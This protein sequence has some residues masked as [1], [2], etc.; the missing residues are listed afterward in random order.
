MLPKYATSASPEA[1]QFQKYGPAGDVSRL[2]AFPYGQTFTWRVTVQ[3]AF[4][5]SAVVLRIH[6]DGETSQDVPFDY[7]STDFEAAVDIYEWTWNTDQLCAP[8]TS[9]LF[10]YQLLFVRA[11]DTMF[12]DS[13]NN[14]DFALVPYGGAPFRLLIYA[15]DSAFP[16]WFGEGVM[17][18][19]F[20][21]R[22]CRGEGPVSYP[23]GAR[24]AIIDPRW[25]QGIPQYVA[26]QGDD[27]PNNVF[28]GGNLWGV[29]QKLDYLESLGVKVLYL[30][31]I[32]KAYSNHKYDTGDYMTVDPGFGGEVALDHLLR[33]AAARGI[34]VILDG[35]FNHTGDDSLY[36]NRY[37]TYPSVGALQSPTSAY[38]NWYCFSSWPDAYDAWWG[39]RIMPKLNHQ[40]PACRHYFTGPDGVCAHYIRKGL[41]GWRL[42]VADELS[43]AFLDELRVAVHD[44]A[45]STP[46]NRT[47]V[48]IGEVW[49][50]AADKIAYGHRRRYLQ[51]H[52][53]D[54]IMNYPVR[55]GLLAFAKEGDAEALYHVLTELYASYPRPV[56]DA[57]MNLVGTHDTP[58]ILTVLGAS[59]EDFERPNDVLATDTLPPERLC[60]AVTLLKIA[61]TVQFTVFGIPSVYYG[62]EVGLEGYHDPF[63]RR[64]FPWGQ[65]EQPL[66]ADLLSFYRQLGQLRR[67]PIFH[68]GEFIIRAH[69]AHHLVYERARDGRRM[70]IAAHRGQEPLHLSLPSTATLQLATGDVS[71]AGSELY[72]APNSAAV[73][74]LT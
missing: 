22:F 64:P 39:I 52:Q 44:A 42:D 63:C 16:T 37:G 68:G 28:F 46:D 31:P 43:D 65:L 11:D 71:L 2:G 59:P 69:G 9:G 73:V 23:S 15:T 49:E 67:D 18:H 35:V 55:T 34:R 45:A 57:L 56:L 12:T 41:S 1:I 30:S 58:R 8:H 50:N 6:R 54:S 36:F 60:T 72:M 5:T 47:P 48:I 33:E 20:V 29:A 3:R 40:N 26:K 24:G 13:I 19:V 21:D 27:L 17:Y 62:D 74:L 66:R 4:G 51:G 38:A 32:F 10:Y 7:I 70:Y 61:A 53:L 25:D 14:V